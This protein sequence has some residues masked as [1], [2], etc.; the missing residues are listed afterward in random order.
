MENDVFEKKSSQDPS[1]ADLGSI[2]VAKGGPRGGLLETKLGS[3]RVRKSEAKK[4]L[5]LGGLGGGW[6]RLWLGNFGPG[7]IRGRLGSISPFAF[8]VFLLS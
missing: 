6:G 3:K 7:V 8:I 5:V 1:W 2:W 4:G